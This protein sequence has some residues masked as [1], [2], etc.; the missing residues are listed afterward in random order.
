VL[1]VTPWVNCGHKS[2]RKKQNEKRS[3][4]KN[5]V[6]AAENWLQAAFFVIFYIIAPA[7]LGIYL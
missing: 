3:L 7:L 4:K 6:L 1:P 2:N 5:R